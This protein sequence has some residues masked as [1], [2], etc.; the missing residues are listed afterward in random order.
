[1]KSI[2]PSSS[3]W[4][5]LSAPG[6]P[7]A[8]TI[9]TGSGSCFST[10]ASSLSPCRPGSSRSSV[11][12]S[13]RSAWMA[14]QPSSALPATPIDLKPGAELTI[15]VI[16]FC[17]SSESSTTRTFTGPPRSACSSPDLHSPGHRLRLEAVE[18]GHFLLVLG[19]ARR[20]LDMLDPGPAGRGLV[21]DAARAR[22]A[23]ILGDDRN[24]L[25]G[26]RNSLTKAMLPSPI[27]SMVAPESTRAPPKTLASRLPRLAPR[28]SKTVDQH[29]HGGVAIALAGMG[30]GAA[31]VLR[32]AGNG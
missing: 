1:M 28:F 27:A 10:R 24:A 29:L 32:A 5:V 4:M 7:K 16:S 8:E 12:M 9:S 30:V 20:R 21:V 25:A 18:I 6:P 19:I 14:S 2:A 22:A 23:D 31:I 3:A 26:L 15:C 17:I 11:R 13:G